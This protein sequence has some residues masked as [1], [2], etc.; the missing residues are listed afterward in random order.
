M[1]FSQVLHKIHQKFFRNFL[2]TSFGK[3]QI[4]I[5][6]FLFSGKLTQ[7]FVKFYIKLVIPANFILPKLGIK[8]CKFYIKLTNIFS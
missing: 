1:K 5:F 6:F 7:K 3:F 4:I 8:L 2:V